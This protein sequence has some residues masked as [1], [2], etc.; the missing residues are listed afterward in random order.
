[1]SSTPRLSNASLSS[2]DAQI[3]VPNY[4][5]DG[6]QTGIVHL[7][8]GAFHRAH[9]AVYTDDAI[10]AD[11]MRWGI[12]GVSLRSP[13]TRDALQ[14]QD[15]LYTV[16]TRDGGGDRFRVI[17]S[18]MGLLVA[19]E[20]PERVLEVMAEPDVKIVSLTI[21]EKGYCY[22]PAAAALDEAHPDIIHDLA[23]PG[24]PI[25]AIG[26]VVEAL[27]RRR[28]RGIPP[29]TLLSCD[30]LPANGE[31]LKNVV[32]RFASLRDAELGRYIT[33]E[34]AFPSTMVDRIVPATTDADRE[35]LTK[36]A[37]VVDEWPIMTE[38]FSQW[39]IEDHFPS[40]RPAWEK[41]GATFV[42]DVAAFELMKLRLLNGSHSTLAYLGYLAG[43]E[44]VSDVMRAEGF[45]GFIETMMDEE[46][47][48]TL[49]PL[50]GFD[51]AAYKAQLRER[52]RNPALRHRTWQIAMDGSQKLPQRLLNTIRSRIEAEAPFPRLA[53]GI[54]AWM[55]YVTGTD[56]R[57]QAI[58]VRD[59]LAEEMK[60]LTAQKASA[61]DIVAALLGLRQVF[62]EDLPANVIFRTA[63]EEALGRLLESGAAR[64][65]A[66][67]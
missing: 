66:A 11:D 21:T 37:G 24:A 4:T 5:R 16:A 63:V 19:P 18:I 40:G 32:T 44:T 38:P 51:L 12:V 28:E 30:N 64:T 43:H 2:L 52:F 10:A 25:S 42:D 35:L 34:V 6:L 48:P 54:A 27:A 31:T 45:A 49:P 47:T 41:F 55:R 9:Q 13:G 36:A 29:F 7:G 60:R 26:F 46:I 62:G 1:M 20:D 15:G 14:P 56:E 33:D 65:V 50:P 22:S 57:G 59:P 39:V 67:T 3:Q 61:P 17:G 8:I 53:M 23:N 58:D